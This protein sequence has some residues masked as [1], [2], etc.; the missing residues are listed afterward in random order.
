[1]AAGCAI[2]ASDLP[3]FREVLGQEDASWF[4]AGN[5][6]AL[7]NAIRGLLDNKVRAQCIVITSYSIHYTKLYEFL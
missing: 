5:P 1:M 2:V 3:V 7:A 6:E 4:D